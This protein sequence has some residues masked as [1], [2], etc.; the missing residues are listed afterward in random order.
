MKRLLSL[1][2]FYSFFTTNDLAWGLRDHEN[3]FCG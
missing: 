1:I 2:I 3:L